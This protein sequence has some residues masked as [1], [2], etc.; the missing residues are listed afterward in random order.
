M[1][2]KLGASD[3]EPT[4][5]ICGNNYVAHLCLCVCVFVFYIDKEYV[6]AW[7]IWR[8]LL[9]YGTTVTDRSDEDFYSNLITII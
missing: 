1:T 3:R 8:L 6:V 2:L 9:S 5:G 7:N 4:A